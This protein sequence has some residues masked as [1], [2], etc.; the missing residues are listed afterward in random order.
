MRV[1]LVEDEQRIASFLT[2]GLQRRDHEVQVVGEGM[3]A[4]DAVV[5][6]GAAHDVLV[7]DLGLPDIDGHE[8]LRRL[9]REGRDIPTI[10]VTARSGEEDRRLAAELGAVDYLVKP[11]PFTRLLECLDQVAE[12]LGPGLTDCSVG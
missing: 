12:R 7:L 9:R 11:F 5:A 6:P 10:V 3:L 1:L 2:R 4:V 8:V